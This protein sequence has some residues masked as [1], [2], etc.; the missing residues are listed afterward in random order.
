MRFIRSAQHFL[1]ILRT[2]AQSVV[3]DGT[4]SGEAPPEPVQI[5]PTQH[6][7]VCSILQYHVSTVATPFPV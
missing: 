1:P 4:S 3:P 2:H 5:I 7:P 6:A